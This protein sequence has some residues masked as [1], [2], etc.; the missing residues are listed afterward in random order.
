MIKLKENN[1]KDGFL[2]KIKNLYEASFPI[3]ERR[4]FQDIIKLLDDKKSPFDVI[5]FTEDGE[6]SGFLSFWKWDDMRYFEHFA[7]EQSMRNG[8]RGAKYLCQSIADDSTPVILEVE[9]PVDEMARR[10]IGF[11]ERNGLRLWNDL[12]YLQ[13]AYGE[14]R[15]P[16]ELKLM[17][18]GE[19]SF[20]GEDDEKILRIKRV[21]YGQNL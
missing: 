9:P 14:G 15:S 18:A 19:I 11:Y 8:G 5:A 6:F 7:V 20:S 3:D 4:D 12:Y 1:C 16:L 17:T 21:V 2:D 13:P 10:R